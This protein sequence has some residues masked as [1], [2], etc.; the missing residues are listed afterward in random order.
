MR[1]YPRLVSEA[2]RIVRHVHGADVPAATVRCRDDIREQVAALTFDDGPSEWT[3][4]ILDILK[5]AGFRATF[6]V[7]GE[8]VRGREQILRRMVA[9]GHEI[10]NHTMRHLWL[11]EVRRRAV[12]RELSDANRVLTAVTGM[13]PT[14]FR[15][16]SFRRNVAVLE[17]ARSAGFDPVVLA[18]AH[19]NDHDCENAST[20][21]EAILPMVRP[22]GI[23]D[24]HDGRPPGDPPAASGGTRD[25]RWPTVHAVQLLLA[26]LPE[27]RFVTVS[28]LLA[29]P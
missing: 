8:A 13:R 11:D 18:S 28:D 17:V 19:T 12:R 23:I 4:P 16:P 7:I 2:A 3:E 1:P 14:V 25:D 21:V 29:L 9:E 26:A 22:G 27:Y 5:G 10:G 24:L 15:P 20:I 6:F